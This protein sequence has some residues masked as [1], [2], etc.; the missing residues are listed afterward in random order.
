MYKLIREG[1]NNKCNSNT[2]IA[3]KPEGKL[4]DRIGTDK[5]L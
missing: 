4:W 2:V 1:I 5:S 3:N